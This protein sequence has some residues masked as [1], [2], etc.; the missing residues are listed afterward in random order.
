MVCDLLLSIRSLPMLGSP[1]LDKFPFTFAF[2]HV[3]Q[4]LS[5]QKPLGVRDLSKTSALPE[6]I[7]ITPQLDLSAPNRPLIARLVRYRLAS[8]FTLILPS[9]YSLRL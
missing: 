4:L 7:A 1:S 9:F 8:T 3:L 6:R 2:I 5:H